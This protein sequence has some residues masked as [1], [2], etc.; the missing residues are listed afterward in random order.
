MGNG[1][2]RRILVIRL[3]SLGD[4]ARLLP[5]L[6]ALNSSP[7][8]A[9]DLTTE[10]RFAKIMDIFPVAREVIPYPRRSAGSPV[11]SPWS[12]GSAMEG[13]F[14][15]LR[16]RRYDVALDLHGIIR[17]AA[18]AHFSGARE[19]AGYARGFGKEGSHLFYERSLAP[20][21]TT[22]ISRYER[23]AGAL[24]ALGAPRPSDEYF[25]PA[26]S[27]DVR[28]KIAKLRG[29]WGTGAGAYA[30]AFIG[31]SAAQR[32]KRW[33]VGHFIA[34]ANEMYRRSGV[35]SVVAWG[36]EEAA[37]VKD[38]PAGPGL[39]IAPLLSLP[40]TVALIEGCG[41]Y[42]GAD[43]GFTHIAALMGVRTVAVMGPTD[44]TLNRPFGNRFRIVFKP[45]IRRGCRGKGC[46]HDDCMAKIEPGE[47]LSAAL[48]L[49]EQA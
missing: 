25:T 21:G 32:H 11:R 3:S 45:G 31:A 41:V 2:G 27:D 9:A 30:V 12:W 39:H 42:V 14:R 15:A 7:G 19:T 28:S 44:P 1:A 33:P 36:P 49:M 38:I 10:D 4:V 43:T 35:A 24:E 13:Y 46:A 5:S 40:E 47:V 26:V 34:C 22:A 18:V 16:E 20:A 48:G 17:S 37:L 29:Q 23:Y 6:R 8:F